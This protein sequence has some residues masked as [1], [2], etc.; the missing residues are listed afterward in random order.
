[1]VLLFLRDVIDSIDGNISSSSLLC[2]NGSL[3][4][5]SN[6]SIASSSFS[7]TFAHPFSFFQY[8]TNPPDRRRIY[9]SYGSNQRKMEDHRVKEPIISLR[10][11]LY[12]RRTL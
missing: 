2:L 9:I 3:P 7:L 11:N 1:M 4:G 5:Q 6:Q 12:Q 10:I 8:H